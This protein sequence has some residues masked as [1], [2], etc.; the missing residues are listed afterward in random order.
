M[1][2]QPRR[3][4]E[5]YEKPAFIPRLRA[6]LDR[7]GVFAYL[8]MTPALIILVVFIAYPFFLGIWLGMS[9]KVASKPGNFVWFRNFINDLQDPIFQ[10]TLANTFAFTFTATIFKL[11][12]GLGLALL[13]NQSF[14]GKNFVRAIVLLPWIVPTVL[15][16]LAWRF[17]IFDSTH[18]VINWLM[19]NWFSMK[20]PYPNWLGDDFLAMVSV[21][22]VNVWRGIPFFA[23]SLLAG[24]QTVSLELYEAAAIDGANAVSRF[25][26][27]TLPTIRPVLIIVTLF[28]VIWTFA[29]FQ[30]VYVLTQGGPANSTHLLATYS[31]QV[32]LNGSQIGTGAS[33]ALFM[34][35][36]LAVVV[37][38][39]Q[40]F[41]KKEG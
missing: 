28:S 26:N 10:R 13:M 38:F 12:L 36:I 11:V 30:I 39:T 17:L 24:L 40:R 23:I 21:I 29:D 8:L 16:T 4:E 5:T 33:I 2:V 20:P 7:E 37:F 35:P 9:D 32:A 31:Y 1:A 19:Q 22:V 27:V 6:F 3:L 18:S 14:K 25:F 41:L 15:S 34:F